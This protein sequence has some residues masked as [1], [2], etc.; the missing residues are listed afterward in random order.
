MGKVL[1]GVRNEGSLVVSINAITQ[2]EKK[3]ATLGE[4]IE[5]KQPFDFH[6]TLS[7]ECRYA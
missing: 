3:P 7:K 4:I 1:I 2:T 5:G 6:E